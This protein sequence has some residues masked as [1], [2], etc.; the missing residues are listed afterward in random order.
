MSPVQVSVVIPVYNEEDGLQALFDRL[1]PALD[2]LG[3]SYEIIF[4][5]DGSVDR[6]A[7]LLA[8]QF[9]QRPDVTRVVLFNGNFGQ[10]MAIL[11]GFEHTRGKIVIT[12]D[13]DLQNP[14][15][16]IPRLVETMRAGHDYVGTIRRQRNDTAFRRYASRAMNR[17]RERITKIRM[18]DQGCML[19]AYDRNV[20]D[21][22]NACREV[23]TFI[24]ALAYTFAS[25]PVEIEV[26]HEQR[27]A[28]ESKYSLYQLIR[29]NFDLVT[30]FSIVPL[31]WFSAIGTILSLF[32]G[33]LFLV[34]LVRRFVMGSEVQGVFTLFAMNFF[35]IGILL[36]GVGL[37]GEYVGR[38]YQEVRDR[39]RYRIKAVLEADPARHAP[40]RTGVEP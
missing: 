4:I 9:H 23:N 18:T 40:V 17:L 15:E 5:N 26:S 38:V 22:I 27:H 33:V 13:A 29:L 31:Q 1:Y 32:S 30:G 16:E 21:T 2:S 39:P 37:L 14:P 25:N 24:P 28:G 10:H 6:S 35:L 7:Q 3:E 12:L 20:I 19:R 36:F 8:A 11:A 34:L